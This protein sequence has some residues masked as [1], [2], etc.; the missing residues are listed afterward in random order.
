MACRPYSLI[1]PHAVNPAS[2]SLPPFRVSADGVDLHWRDRDDAQVLR[3][4]GHRVC[5]LA[6]VLAVAVALALAVG[7]GRVA[8][9]GGVV[10]LSVIAVKGAE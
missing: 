7:I 10:A 4:L 2:L 9:V 3:E 6:G 1:E 8:V 5:I